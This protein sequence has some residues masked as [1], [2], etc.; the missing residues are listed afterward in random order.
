MV[1]MGRDA[2]IPTRYRSLSS[3][4]QARFGERVYK[5]SIDAGF[6]CPNRDGKKAL[7]GCTFCNNEGFSPPTRVD[8]RDLTEQLRQ[9]ITFLR[10]RSHSRKFLAY[11][12]AFT[13]TYAPIETLRKRYDVIRNFPEIVGLVIGTRP[14]CVPEETLDLIAEY[15]RDYHVWVE[16]GLQSAHDRSLGLINR[17]HTVTDFTDAVTRTRRRSEQ[18]LDL[19]ICAHVIL[20]LPRETREDMLE[21]AR[22]VAS[23]PVDGIK[24]HL[25]HILRGT[26]MEQ[27][28]RIGKIRL[29][30]LDEYAE[31]VCDFLELLPPEMVIQRLTGEAPEDYLVAP[32]WCIDKN[33]VLQVIRSALESRDTYQGRLFRH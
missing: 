25:L 26:V 23:L 22:Y 20:G 3:Y 15:A 17:A 9:G 30:E 2:L 31:L 14:D 12:Q 13:N 8:T 27:Q 11:F 24:I 6:T 33:K 18:G 16:Y 29:L 21:T 32:L 19:Q 7:G 1:S 4:L 10:R 28:Y 5:V